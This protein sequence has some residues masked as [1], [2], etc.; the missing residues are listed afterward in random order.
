LIGFN[1]DEK[2]REVFPPIIDYYKYRYYITKDS[3][4]KNNDKFK[5]KVEKSLLKFKLEEHLKSLNINLPKEDNNNEEEI[6]FEK[7]KSNCCPFDEYGIIQNWD[8]M[9][10]IWREIFSKKLGVSPEKHNIILTEGINNTKENRK[11]MG[12]IM[13]ETFH[14]PKLFI[15]KK[16]ALPLFSQYSKTGLM[17][18]FGNDKITIAPIFEGYCL[19]PIEIFEIPSHSPFFQPN[20]IEK[21]SNIICKYDFDLR[22]ELISCIYL[23]GTPSRIERISDQLSHKYYYMYGSSKKNP[24]ISEQFTKIIQGLI[25]SCYE[26][27][28]VKILP[29]NTYP[30]W[31]GAIQLSNILSESDWISKNEYE[32]IG[33]DIINRKCF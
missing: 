28:N 29:E 32:E 3:D 5:E 12:E 15:A 8:D 17:V 2:P 20:I 18:D 1:Y 23:Y 9:E 19:L 11:K 30:Y 27:V 22:K 31:E 7:I 26:Y 21:V 33:S 10:F 24:G 14:T 4:P 13:F 25:P 16:L 6:K